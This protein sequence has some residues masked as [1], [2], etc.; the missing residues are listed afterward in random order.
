MFRLHGGHHQ[1]GLQ[2][3][4]KE[5]YFLHNG[6]STLLR[7]IWFTIPSFSFYAFKL[8]LCL[9][10]RYCTGVEIKHS[11]ILYGKLN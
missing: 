6:S 7:K 4:P 3:I 11:K 9:S 8:K 10:Q 2:N 1:A 5:G